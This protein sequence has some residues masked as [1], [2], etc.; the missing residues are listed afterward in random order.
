M[1]HLNPFNHL[2]IQGY[3][4]LFYRYRNQ[5]LLSPFSRTPLLVNLTI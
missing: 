3:Q 2:A 4:Q 1:P 5:T